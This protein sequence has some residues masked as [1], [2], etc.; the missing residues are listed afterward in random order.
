MAKL[1][2]NTIYDGGQEGSIA[3][4]INSLKTSIESMQQQSFMRGVS[5]ESVKSKVVSF[6]EILELAKVYDSN[7]YEVTDINGKINRIFSIDQ[8]SEWR[9]TNSISLK[10]IAK[11]WW[12]DKVKAM[13]FTVF[14]TG[15]N[16]ITNTPFLV[17]VDPRLEY[18]NKYV[19]SGNCEFNDKS[20]II[21]IRGNVSDGN[22]IKIEISPI[23]PRLYYNEGARSFCW[24]ING[25]RTSVSAQGISGKDG[26]SAAIKEVTAIYKNNE[27][28]KK[29]YNIETTPN[30]T[31]IILSYNEGDKR[32]TCFD[33]SVTE[34]MDNINDGTMCIINILGVSGK[35]ECIVDGYNNGKLLYGSEEIA[36]VS[37]A[38]VTFGVTKKNINDNT[39]EIITNNIKFRNFIKTISGSAVFSDLEHVTFGNVEAEAN[40]ANT[41][42]F[43]A[44]N[45]TYNNIVS[46]YSTT[47]DVALSFVHGAH[48]QKAYSA[49][50]KDEY[51]KQMI[52]IN[53]KSVLD[54]INYDVS[55]GTDEIPS[56]FAVHGQ[57]SFGNSYQ[58]VSVYINSK[59]SDS[60]TPASL[61]ISVNNT[62]DKP[63]VNLYT[64]PSSQFL[65]RT[66]N[67][68][69]GLT[70]QSLS[71]KS[72]INDALTIINNHTSNVNGDAISTSKYA[73]S[74]KVYNKLEAKDTEITGILK[75]APDNKYRRNGI[76]LDKVRLRTSKEANFNIASNSI[77]FGPNF[78]EMAWFRYEGKTKNTIVLEGPVVNGSR[79]T[80]VLNGSLSVKYSANIDG[81]LNAGN[82]TVNLLTASNTTVGSLNALDTS[83]KKLNVDGASKFFGIM[84]AINVTPNVLHIPNNGLTKYT[85][86]SFIRTSFNKFVEILY[87]PITL[88]MGNFTKIQ[89]NEFVCDM[90]FYYG[91]KNYSDNYSK[92]LSGFSQNGT[93]VTW[94]NGTPAWCKKLLRFYLQGSHGNNYLEIEPYYMNETDKFQYINASA[95]NT[96]VIIPNTKILG[97]SSNSSYKTEIRNANS[98]HEIICVTMYNNS[99]NQVPETDWKQNVTLEIYM[100]GYIFNF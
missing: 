37:T 10:D 65:I 71:P 69:K 17:F 92:T 76:D 25:E 57:A 80:A 30:D 54:I 39:I 73:N 9:I 98:N 85:F 7:G 43:K 3:N 45:D 15:E 53:K 41:M 31:L 4:M 2:I 18:I 78:E 59:A 58:P 49:A 38:D 47:G 6:K 96:A 51:Y 24:E 32:Y 87:V 11:D 27:G 89:N 79:P 94:P 91:N 55:I 34:Y 88:K 22:D 67:S 1:R 74:V 86:N 42:S 83:V 48:A 5:G 33:T 100:L 14:Y 21:A 19:N 13:K 90:S 35:D 75:V 99:N 95:F 23:F 44:G 12:Y 63:L 70:I 36:N 72:G 20:C 81:T 97:I 93:N 61:N 64:S 68:D 62:F 50:N 60:I 82:T 8:S 26:E 29:V 28:D 56:N 66:N 52:G 16:T 77:G 46:S 84:D 40:N